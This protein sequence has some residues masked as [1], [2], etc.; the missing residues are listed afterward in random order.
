M[1]FEVK[2]DRRFIL[3]YWQVRRDGQLLGKGMAFT[4]KG[5]SIKARRVLGYGYVPQEDYSMSDVV[6][7]PE[8]G[9]DAA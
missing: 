2:Y 5:A 7:P 4:P 9:D 8:P 3:T 1:L 6:V